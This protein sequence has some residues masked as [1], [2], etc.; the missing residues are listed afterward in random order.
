M[1]PTTNFQSAEP[2]SGPNRPQFTLRRMLSAVVAISIVCAV[3]SLSFRTQVQLRQQAAEIGRLR[4]ELGQPGASDLSAIDVV[5]VPTT[6]E[7]IW[8]WKIDLPPQAR[9]Q[10]CTRTGLIPPTG[11]A[12][13]HP[14]ST[15]RDQVD[16]GQLIL[17]GLL[18]RDTGGKWMVSIVERTDST[19][20]GA[21]TNVRIPDAIAH[22]FSAAACLRPV[23]GHPQ[24][25][26]VDSTGRIELLRARV[27]SRII[28]VGDHSRRYDPFLEPV[29]GVLVWLEP[30]P[31]R[32]R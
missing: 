21:Q 29:D 27:G 26:N 11:F 2:I 18:Q 6:N 23:L 28:K 12:D 20:P 25:G 5:F 10:L 17:D 19:A 1:A 9:W 24:I 8:M 7:N 4:A 14:A 22:E 13:T 31:R 32:A 30:V 15:C 3:V 16:G